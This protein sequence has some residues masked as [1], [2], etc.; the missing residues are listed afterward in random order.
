MDASRR[1]PPADAQRAAADAVDRLRA[2]VALALARD[3]VENTTV[4]VALSGGRDSMALLDAAV[5][6]AA[7]LSLTLVACHVH[8]GLSPHADTWM[9]ACE[10]ACARHGVR[11]AAQRV[12]VPRRARTSLEAAARTARYDALAAMAQAHGASAVLARP[13]TGRPGRDA[14]A[15]VAARRRSARPRGDAGIAA[16]AR[17]AVGAPAAGRAARAGRCV[18][19]CRAVAYVDDDS[20]VATRFR[21]NA[22]R[23]GVVPTLREA[24]PGYP[25]TIARAARH[26]A[27]AAQL[28]HELAVLDAQDGYDGVTLDR[29]VLAGLAPHRARNLLRWF[30]HERGLPPPSTARLA[31]MQMQLRGARDDAAVR[32]RHAGVEIGLFRNRIYAHAAAPPALR[33]GVARRAHPRAAARRAATRGVRARRHRRRAHCSRATSSCAAREGG[34]RVRLASAAQ[35]RALQRVLR[36]AALP[37]WQRDALPLVFANGVL[38]AVP[39]IGIDPAFAVP[40]DRPGSAIVWSASAATPRTPPPS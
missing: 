27:E 34:E 29:A 1:S 32:V 7:P 15:A 33:G 25:A 20:N 31:A 23:Q 8:H 36:E 18:R 21:R 16:H 6:V 10:A 17:P 22:L 39:G 30:L 13:S 2:A 40:P 19:R 35:P 38:A 9:A 24:A 37:P 28:M 11:F 5:A 4:A 12:T 26:Q 14:A 3:G